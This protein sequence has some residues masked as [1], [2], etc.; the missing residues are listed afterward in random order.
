MNVHA[1]N[2]LS[3]LM[4]AVYS[5]D[6]ITRTDLERWRQSAGGRSRAKKYREPK[7]VAL[8]VATDIRT[9]QPQLTGAALAKRVRPRLMEQGISPIPAARTIRHWLSKNNR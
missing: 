7:R 8:E 1:S 3:A 2:V 5:V 4:A 9:R 6:V